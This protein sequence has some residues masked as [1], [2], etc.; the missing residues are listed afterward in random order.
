MAEVRQRTLLHLFAVI[1]GEETLMRILFILIAVLSSSGLLRADE[2]RS[3]DSWVFP[4]AD[5]KEQSSLPVTV[6]SAHKKNVQSVTSRSGQYIT[7]KPFHEVVLFYARQS[8]LNPTNKS[9]LAREYPG[10]D[11]Y[12]PAHTSSINFYREEPSVTV[13]HYIRENVAT[14]QLLVTDHPEL[15]FLSVSVTRGK[16]DDQTV[17]QLIQHTANRITKNNEQ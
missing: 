3:F 15:G 7:D 17:I 2:S 9:I 11:V 12:I 5:L 16:H 4:D 10:T 6:T 8:G 1:S 13:L 14:V